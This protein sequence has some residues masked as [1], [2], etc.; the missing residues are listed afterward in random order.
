MAITLCKYA[1]CIRAVRLFISLMDKVVE[2]V[3]VTLN[4]FSNHTGIF[5]KEKKTVRAIAFEYCSNGFIDV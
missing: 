5:V 3:A 4:D 1:K 2:V